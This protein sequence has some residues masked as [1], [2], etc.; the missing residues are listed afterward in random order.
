QQWRGRSLSWWPSPLERVKT[1]QSFRLVFPFVW[2][3]REIPQVR[4]KHDRSHH[5]RHIR[6]LCA[7]SILVRIGPSTLLGGRALS[8]SEHARP[9]QCHE[10]AE[11]AQ[12]GSN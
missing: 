1:H 12:N 7:G 4:G 2:N 10:D 3:V 5:P 9:Q 8:L 6:S 11:E